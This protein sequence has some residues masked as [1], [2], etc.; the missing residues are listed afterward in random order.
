MIF[1][2]YTTGLFF[3]LGLDYWFVNK[4]NDYIMLTN[5][6]V[7]TL[8]TGDSDGNIILTHLQVKEVRKMKVMRLK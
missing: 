4:F 6:M 5:Q 3:Y 1:N 7:F 8:N 2:S